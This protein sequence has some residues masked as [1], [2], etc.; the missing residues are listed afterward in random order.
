MVIRDS[1]GMK[2]SCWIRAFAGMTPGSGNDIN[3][4]TRRVYRFYK[5]GCLSKE[6]LE[7]IMQILSREIILHE[8]KRWRDD[9]IYKYQ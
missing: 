2:L 8:S 6:M 4:V 7:T 3:M 1:C 5:L 9:A